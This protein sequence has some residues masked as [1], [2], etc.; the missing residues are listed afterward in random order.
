MKKVLS[1][2]PILT[3]QGKR[4]LKGLKMGSGLEQCLPNHL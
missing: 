3:L 4:L 1:C 2:L